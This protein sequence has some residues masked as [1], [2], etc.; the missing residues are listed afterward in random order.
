MKLSILLSVS[1]AFAV[2]NASLPAYAQCGGVNWSGDSSCASGF[3]C[4]KQSE[5]YSQCVP[6]AAT[7][8]AK[9]T[10]T[11]RGSPVP[12]TSVPPAASIT[13]FAKADGNV[14]NINGK[15]QYFMGTNS[16]WIGFFTSNSDV[17]L[18]FSHL[19]STGLKV[20]RVWG[21]NDV[22]TIPGAGTVWFQSF[23][24]GSA[25]TINTGPEGLQR[26]DYV[27]ESAGKH[28]VS[29]II[30]F[31]NNW[32]DY[33][34]IPAYNTYYGLSSTNRTEWYTSAAAQS[35][36]QKY[37]STVVARYKN[38]P[39][40]FAWE[41]ANEP[42]CNGCPTS[43]L[44]NWIKTTSA[45]IKSLDSK[46]MVTT[47]DEGFGIAGGTSYVWGP[48]EGI[49]WVENLKISTIDFGTAHLYPESWG[50]QDSFGKPWIDAHAAAAKAL[51]KPFIL[52][53]YGSSTKPSILTWEK[54]VLDS[55]T[56]GDMY[57]Q[58]GDSFSWGQTHNDGNSIYYGTDMYKT[59]VQDHAA[60]M[61]AKKV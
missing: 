5:W 2:V 18:V 13:S 15:S 35:Q 10:T 17:D 58:Y 59:Y 3:Y 45:Y 9:P 1:S 47:G 41:L 29:L 24:R 34:G 50:E 8:T 49:D 57:W 11:T 40:V 32:A 23:V 16:Y 43:V 28:G 38:N 42:R 55:G 54:A 27:V 12:T 26:L 56:A 52:E 21:F 19:A 30:N 48:G 44:T 60:A 61:A 4:L 7:V 22:T 31:V 46:H 39:T 36:Y 25:P 37:I 33:G 20:L 53:E 14:F 51:G 6:G